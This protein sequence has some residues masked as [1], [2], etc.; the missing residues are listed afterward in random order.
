M[1]KN[2]KGKVPCRLQIRRQLD[3]K[4]PIKKPFIQR[5]LA[6]AWLGYNQ[7]INTEKS[8]AMSNELEISKLI[9]FKVPQITHCVC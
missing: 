3:A 7:E 9:C 6:E 1:T 4:V 8:G 5:I 2:L